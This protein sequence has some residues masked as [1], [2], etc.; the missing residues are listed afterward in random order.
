MECTYG[1]DGMDLM[2]E[3][4]WD[5]GRV[6]ERQRERERKRERGEGEAEAWSRGY[7]LPPLHFE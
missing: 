3:I 5:V 7:P 6:R 4:G 1:I 2:F